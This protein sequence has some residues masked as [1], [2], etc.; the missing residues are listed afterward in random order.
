MTPVE[1]FLRF[2]E[3]GEVPDGLFAPDVFLDFTM[4]TWRLQGQGIEELVALRKAGHPGPSTV[5]H[6]RI[7]PIANGFVV[8]FGESW[9]DEQG[10]WTAREMARAD[11]VDG[12]ITQVSVY[13]TGDWDQ[14]RRDEHAAAVRLLRP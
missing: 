11:V 6:R 14:A 1:G 10:S 8:E 9:D 5:P 12:A 7:D 13:C 3:T 4:P 2:V